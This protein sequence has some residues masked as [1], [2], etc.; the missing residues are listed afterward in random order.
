M[1]AGRLSEVG[2]RLRVTR[3]GALRAGGVG[4]AGLGSAWLLACGGSK[5]TTPSGDGSAGAAATAVSTAA[6]ENVK[7]GGVYQFVLQNDPP[8][9]DPFKHG[10]TSRSSLPATPTAS[11]SS[12]RPAKACGPTISR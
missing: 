8:S 1:L 4:V 10:A 6:V 9:T 12:I 5:E 11:C 7:T 3:R 2:A